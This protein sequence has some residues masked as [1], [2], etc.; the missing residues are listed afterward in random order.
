MLYA[1]DRRGGAAETQ[2]KGD[3]QGLFLAKRNKRAFDAQAML[4]LPTGCATRYSER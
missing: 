3:K 2:F 1:Y 4:V